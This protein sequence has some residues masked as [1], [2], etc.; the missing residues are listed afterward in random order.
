M[1]EPLPTQSNTTIN[2]DRANGVRRQ[3]A[4]VQLTLLS[5]VVALILENLMGIMSE[6]DTRPFLVWLQSLDILV[7][8][9]SMW[10]GYAFAFMAGNKRPHITDFFTPFGL[11]IFLH[12]AAYCMA[13]GNLSGF[14]FAGAA[15]TASAVVNLWANVAAAKRAGLGGPLT[16]AKLLTAGC[17]VEILG[18]LIYSF[19]NP[20]PAVASV[21]ILAAISLQMATSA[22]SIKG[23][24]SLSQE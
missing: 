1:N 23:W 5:L 11:L 6:L 12:L 20:G 10:V 2:S 24:L 4:T 17:L 7:S 22:E 9:F 15:G 19:G 16:T 21:L 13:T 3:F 14:F 18:G 8:A